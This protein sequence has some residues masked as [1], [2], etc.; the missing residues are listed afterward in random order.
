M[1]KA[2][3]GRNKDKAYA[4]IACENLVHLIYSTKNRPVR[5]KAPHTSITPRVLWVGKE[6]FR[7]EADAQSEPQAQARG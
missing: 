4:S 5:C 1:T 2:L 7:N 3:K 6:V